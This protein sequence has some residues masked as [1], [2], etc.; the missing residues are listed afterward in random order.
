MSIS[1][2]S[3]TRRVYQAVRATARASR[4]ARQGRF[5][6]DFVFR[7]TKGERGEVVT[8]CDNLWPLKFSPAPPNEKEVLSRLVNKHPNSSRA[9]DA[10]LYLGQ[11]Y[12]GH[13]MISVKTDCPKAISLFEK[14]K[15]DRDWIKAQ[16]KGRIGQC[17]ESMGRTD[18]APSTYKQVL[19]DYPGTPWGAEVRQLIKD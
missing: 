15:A 16:A 11:T 12:S 10:Y 7:L 3:A 13:V 17:L 6:D 1:P 2:P 4:L 18:E 8:L 19:R 9:A 5:P 14:A